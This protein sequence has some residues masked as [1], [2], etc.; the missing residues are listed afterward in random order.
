MGAGIVYYWTIIIKEAD[1]DEAV[2]NMERIINKLN[3]SHTIFHFIDMR[4]KA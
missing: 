1:S 4:E 2:E 3:Q